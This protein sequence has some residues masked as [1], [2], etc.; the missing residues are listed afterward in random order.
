MSSPR[1][2]VRRVRADEAARVRELREAA[3]SDP[4]APLAFVDDRPDSTEIEEFW[5]RR[6]EHAATGERIAQFIAE[7]EDGWQA[8]ASVL[9]REPGERSALGTLLMAPRSD[10]VGVFVRPAARGSGVVD[11]LLDE[12]A[13]WAKSLGDQTLFL[14]VHIDNARAQAAYRRAGFV[15]TGVSFQGVVGP[16]IEMRRSL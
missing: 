9:R 3:L 14:D 10:V 13:A 7:S 2:I 6:A 8:T 1:V 4:D 16:E 11:L 5:A 12:A 15:S